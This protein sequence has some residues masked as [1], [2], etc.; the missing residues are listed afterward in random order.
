MH[1][2]FFWSNKIDYSL[3]ILY[4]DVVH[5]AYFFSAF[6]SFIPLLLNLFLL[7]SPPFPPVFMSFVCVW[8]N[9]FFVWFL[10]FN[11]LLFFC[12]FHSIHPNPSHLPILYAFCPCKFYPTETERLKQKQKSTHGSWL[13]A[14]NTCK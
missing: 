3:I 14:I 6:L 4:M 7:K 12:E 9:E 13:I 2:F 1:Y 8:S 11:F 5:L 10:L